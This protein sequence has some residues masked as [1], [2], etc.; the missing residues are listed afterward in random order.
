MSRSQRFLNQLNHII[1]IHLKD[2]KFSV[3]DIAKA[4]NISESTVR[5]KLRQYTGLTPVSYI[6]GK[7]L[8]KAK[9]YLENDFGSVAE[10]A[11]AVG[12][13][14]LSYF[15]KCFHERFGETPSR[16][17]LSQKGQLTST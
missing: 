16:F 10:I 14:N 1:E 3:G 15:A 13:T 9:E 11:E 7:R 6:R 4:M 12:F 5:R 17:R 2:N 8:N